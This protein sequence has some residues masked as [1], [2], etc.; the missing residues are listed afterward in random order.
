MKS[1]PDLYQEARKAFQNQS[2]VSLYDTQVEVFDPMQKNK[3][4]FPDNY[5]DAVKNIGQQVSNS[6]AKETYWPKGSNPEQ[7]VMHMFANPLSV[8]G[9]GTVA[10]IL[11]PQIEEK[12][13]NSYIHVQTTYIYRSIV[14]KNAPVA[15]WVWHYDNYPTEIYKVMIYLTD[16]DKKSGPF[17]YLIDG[18]GKPVMV[19]PSRTGPKHWN[20]PKWKGSRV[21]DKQMKKFEQ[22]GCRSKRVIGKPGTC[23][24]FDN[25][26][27]HRANVAKRNHRD[28]LV[29]QIRP[30]IKK[31]RPLLH[32]NHTGSFQHKGIIQDPSALKPEPTC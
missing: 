25:N 1:Y 26:C 30:S 19:E 8:D 10:N 31:I 32:K 9:V 5:L 15:S 2:S 21:S 20:K 28:V 18:K 27:I 22:A 17:E 23:M 4:D 14:T 11:I 24:L 13:F 7:A 12:Y 3:L 29:F 6:I 16:V